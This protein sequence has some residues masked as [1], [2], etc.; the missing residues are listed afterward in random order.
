VGRPLELVIPFGGVPGLS[1]RLPAELGGEGVV[2]HNSEM[3]E[4]AA[5]GER[6]DTD[7][8][9]QSD[10]VEVSAFQRKVVRKRL[11]APMSC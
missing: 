6:R 11:K 4:Q 1:Q 10:C 7:A 2:L 8:G 5:D 3:L 9:L